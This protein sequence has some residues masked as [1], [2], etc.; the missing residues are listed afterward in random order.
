[1]SGL[2]A[3]FAILVL[4]ESALSVCAR[5][6]TPPAIPTPPPPEAVCGF[7]YGP[8]HYYEARSVTRGLS[9]EM[10]VGDVQLGQPVILR[11]FVN[12]KPRGTP[13]A[14]LQLE[15]E[16]LIHVIGVRDDL[17]DF[18]HIHPVNVG[19]G[20]WAASLVFTNA[21]NYK[22]WSDVKY[23]GVSYAFGQ[24]MLTI[25]GKL[26]EPV[27]DREPG[28]SVTISGYHVVLKHSEP[29]IAG[30][31]NQLQFSIRDSTGTE[32]SPENFLGAPMHL[33]IV[34]D[35]LT[36][37]L[38]AHPDHR[39]TAD[40][41]INFRQMF[42]REGDYKLFAQFRPPK[43]SLPPDD[44]LLAEFYVHVSRNGPEAAS[45]P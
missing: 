9:V 32:I 30:R 42:D 4:A 24:P 10:F 18:F 15:H 40:P 43:T 12:I 35:D 8:H 34:R 5:Q 23:S 13:V 1:M 33:V 41:K 16:K 36:T 6:S 7:A 19:P 38:H 22:I 28:D 37:C 27:A 3:F 29:L 31:T 11:F 45:A 21:G 20:L 25:S 14:R 26:E 17:K 44:A 2:K 39:I